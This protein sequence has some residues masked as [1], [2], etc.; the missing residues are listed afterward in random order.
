MLAS[1]A[2]RDKQVTYFNITPGDHTLPMLGA[3][4]YEPYSVGRYL[5]VPML[6]ATAV[7][8]SIEALAPGVN[9]ADLPTF[10][11]ELL[12]DHAGYGCISV[13]CRASDQ[14]YPFVFLPLR[15][16]R[17]VPVAYLAYC[18]DLD[19]FV[20]FAGSLGRFLAAEGFRW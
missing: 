19:N 13:V 8:T 18:R 7:D 11:T 14:R 5:V 15:T 3:Q 12:L 9:D 20:R 10:E 1:H 16:L 17:V 2:L 6:S 4:G